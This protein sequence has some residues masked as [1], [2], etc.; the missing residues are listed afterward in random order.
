M[1]LIVHL[2]V[3]VEPL[4]SL[5]A[6]IETGVSRVPAPRNTCSVHV[7]VRTILPGIRFGMIPCGAHWVH[8][9]DS[10]SHTADWSSAKARVSKV[11]VA[12]TSQSTMTLDAYAAGLTTHDMTCTMTL[13]AFA[14]SYWLA[15][16]GDKRKY[17]VRRVSHPKLLWRSLVAPSP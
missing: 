4:T 10:D 3:W 13:Q 8:D 5:P 14:Y 6:M 7:C 17:H 2:R 11:H 9:R 1:A 12:T 15:Q 16:C